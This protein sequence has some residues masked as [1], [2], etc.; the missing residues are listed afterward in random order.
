LRTPAP[1]FDVGALHPC[2]LIVTASNA[3]L[4]RREIF[5][6][7][8]ILFFILRACRGRGPAIV[9]KPGLGQ[10]HDSPAFRLKQKF[11][12]GER[13]ALVML[14]AVREHGLI[15]RTVG[16]TDGIRAGL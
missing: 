1:A 14:P 11:G 15:V 13:T 9:K 7:G 10:R 2:A 5:S 16:P 12:E 4:A 8:D 3:D 6:R